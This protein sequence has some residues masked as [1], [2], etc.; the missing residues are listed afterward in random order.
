MTKEKNS[1]SKSGIHFDRFAGRVLTGIVLAVGLLG[2]VG[3]WGLSAQ[4][5]SA[6]IAPGQVKVD[7]NLK[8]VQHRDGGIVAKIAVREGDHVESGQMLFRLEDAQSRA[9]LSILMA[10]LADAQARRARL[11]S[12]RDG[13]ETI[14]FPARLLGDDPSHR[15]LIAAETRL[16]SGNIANRENQRQQL[17]FGIEQVE[18]E[19]IALKV[20]RDALRDELNL[21][22]R[23]HSRIA[24]L[25]TR[26]LI[27]ARR[28]EEVERESVQIKGR[29]GEIDA[30]IARSASRIAEVR[31]RILAIDEVARTEAQRELTVVESRL[32]ELTDR[33]SAVEDRLAR[34]EIRAPISGQINELSVFTE[35]GVITPAQVLASIVPDGARL[36]IEV[37]LPTTAI[38]QVFMGQ[39][40]RVRFSS[41]NHRTTPEVLGRIVYISPAT[42]M[43]RSDAE[44]H[45]VGLVELN[46][47]EAERLG[48]LA[49]MPGMQAEVYMT[50]QA[51]TAAAY[52]TRPLVDQFERAFREE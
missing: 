26:G 25:S 36:R 22:V 49:L 38:D 32:Q 6:V 18:K 48:N 51:Q 23:S 19:I 41:F 7:Q 43:S 28:I 8:E 42:A 17:R 46:E 10:Q 31:M 9:E 33:I 24:D 14:D 13:N 2:G 11:I 20:Q 16:H 15:E 21:V 3:S 47:G 27:E 40:A 35:G 29:L 50:S 34:T 4:L 1:G 12:D 5:T 39:Q 44:P 45:Y 30:N 37:M 52:F